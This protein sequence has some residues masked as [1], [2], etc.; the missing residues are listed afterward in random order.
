M[1]RPHPTDHGA[2]PARDSSPGLVPPP[3]SS[4]PTAE[5]GLFA[6]IEPF[7]Q[8]WLEV[9]DGHR[10]YFE[11]CGTAG[12]PAAL[13]LHGGPGS[14]CSAR[15][16]QLLDPAWRIVL[17]DQRGCGRS[18]PRGECKANTTANL[19]TDIERLRHHLGIDRWVVF[20]GSWGS[21]LGL[22]YCALHRQA[23]AGA[24]LRGIFLTGRAD[25]DWFFN[26]AGRVLPDHW[27]ALAD[28]AP[29]DQ[30]HRL[31]QWYL[32]TVSGDDTDRAIEAVRRWMTWEEAL[33][34]PGS[35]PAADRITNREAAAAQLAKYR[36]QA[37][38]LR[39][40]CFIGE[41]RMLDLAGQL[42]GLP[43]LILHGRRDLVCRPTNALA[44]HQALPGSRLQFVDGAGHSPFDLPMTGALTQAGDHFLRE[45]RL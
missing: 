2:A 44:L 11:Q 36:V 35:P 12:G 9:G 13:F 7:D 22:V 20:G 28:L 33:T 10:I 37:H 26:G 16:R 31:A 6:P 30:R 15:H 42:E 14:G 40:E 41:A 34:R 21:S 27:A 17:F 8:G 5:G 4:A 32:D 45:R 1:M 19:V 18:T 25:L 43:V 39:H 24:I 38:Y 23:C 29:V 3:A